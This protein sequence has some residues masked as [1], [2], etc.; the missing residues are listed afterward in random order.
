MTNI[1]RYN[2]YRKFLADYYEEKK[3]TVQYFSYMNFSRKAGF[4]SKSFVFN[5]IRGRKNLSRSSVVKL[6]RLLQLGKTEAAY[7]ENL[8]Y[9]NQAKNFSERDFYYRQL[10]AIHHTT[11][12]ASSAKQLRKDQYEFYSNWYH[13]VIRSLIDLYP[14]VKDYR[15]IAAML[16]PAVTPKQAQKSIELLLRLRLIERQADGSCKVCSKVLITGRDIQSLAV[17]HFHLE[18]MELAAKALRELPREKRNISGLTLGISP[19]A[20]AKIEQI[21]LSCQEEILDIA[22]KDKKSDRVYQLNFQFFPVSR[23]KGER[24]FK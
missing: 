19:E 24:V 3:K 8:V 23:V 17:Q 9:F 11:S 10:N 5:V 1:F 20:Y 15:S 22:D 7:F 14:L 12:E 21:I 13:A 18:C 16:Y 4:S 6:C 2:D